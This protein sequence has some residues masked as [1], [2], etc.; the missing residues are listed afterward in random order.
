MSS[1]RQI[2]LRRLGDLLDLELA[3]KTAIEKLARMADVSEELAFMLIFSEEGIKNHPEL[4][5]AL[6]KGFNLRD[7][8]TYV[9][10]KSG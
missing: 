7:L 9:K 8:L 5:E 6:K 1:T 2:E 3:N 4:Q 10:I